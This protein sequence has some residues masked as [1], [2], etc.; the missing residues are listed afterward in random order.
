MNDD[1]WQP[2]TAPIPWPTTERRE[3]DPLGDFDIDRL[4]VFVPAIMSVGLIFSVVTLLREAFEWTGGRARRR[5]TLIEAGAVVS[6]LLGEPEPDPEDLGLLSRPSYLVSAVVLVGGAVYIA[7][8]SSANFLRDQGYVRDIGWLLALSL[9]LALLLGFLGGVSLSVFRSWPYPPTWTM[10]PLRVAP[11]TGTPGHQGRGPSW[12]LTA[13]VW[14]AAVVT[15]LV[16]ILVGSGRSIARDIDEPIAQ[17]LVESEWINQLRFLDLFGS[18]IISIGF[19]VFIG[20][21]GFRCRVMA[22]SYPLAFLAGWLGGAA[23]R[24]IVDRPR[25]L[26]L[27]DI[28]SF[29]SGHMVQAVFI[30]GLLPLAVRVMLSDNRPATIV[31]WVLGVTVIASGLHRIHRQSHWPLDVTAGVALGLTVV[32]GTYWAIEHREWHSH[33]G[34]CPWS[35]RPGQTPWRRGVLRLQPAVAQRV[36][37]LAV[38]LALLAAGALAALTVTV[39]LPTDPEGSGFGSAISGPVQLGLAA[40]M[41]V[42]GVIAIRIRSLAAFLMALAATG[43]GLFASVQ[44]HPALAVALTTLLLIPA[45]MTW[46]AWQPVETIGTITTLAAITVSLLTATTLGA[47]AIH[48]HFFGPT[49]PDSTAVDLPLEEADWAWLGNV[50]ARQAS[51]VVGGIDDDIDYIELWYWPEGGQPLVDGAGITT[52]VDDGL[53]G[54]AWF[55]LN[56]LRPSTAYRYA[57]VEPGEHDESDDEDE[58]PAEELLESSVL[59]RTFDE[60]PQDL[61]VTLSSCARLGSNGAVFDAMVG[62]EPDLYLAL[63]DLHYANLESSDPAAHVEQYA[64]ALS[65]PGQAAL[66]SGTPTAYVWDDHDYGPNDADGS[67]PSRAAVSFAYREAVPNYGV[68][69]DPSKS[70]AQAFSVGRVRFVFADTRSMRTSSTM[71]GDEQLEWLIEELTTSAR[72]HALVVWA[73]PT[74]WLSGDPD[75]VRVGA[76]DWSAYP[77]ER[78]RIADA[79]ETAKVDNLIMVSGDAHMLALDD[80]TNNRYSTTGAAGFPILHGAAL[81]RPGSVKGGPYSHGAFPG[82]GQYAKIEIDDDGGSTISVR[83]SGHNWAGEQMVDLDLIFDVRK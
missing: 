7:V 79:L 26:A 1:R 56:D 69:D 66:F 65:R 5:R 3:E 9:S 57:L 30:A 59:F 77:Q 42:A 6:E 68:D 63:G 78:R 72:T 15:G 35:D 80:G 17:W 73:N 49:H 34:G 13:S 19:V 47:Q 20:F 33:C 76:D 54:L 75:E 67:S 18:T 61:V 28:E 11:L 58:D 51:I 27:S 23:I 81:D 2:V 50:G 40:L 43:L 31:R 64:R 36:G 71:L 62:E 83:L 70:I 44:Y 60:G 53:G 48:E 37:W 22:L 12:A 46:L 29:P 10:G 16:S 21:S 14:A 55:D 4:M 38:T 74:P 8:G 82:S 24:E 45:V 39:G 52:D 32:L 41:G 25:P